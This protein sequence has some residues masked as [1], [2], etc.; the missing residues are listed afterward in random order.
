VFSHAARYSIGGRGTLREVFLGQTNLDIIK[1]ASRSE[2]SVVHDR[3]FLF[4]DIT[5]PDFGEKDRFGQRFSGFF[6]PPKS[7]LYTF[8]VRSDDWSR[9]Y[10]SPNSS[11]DHAKL[12]IS[13]DSH[14]SHRY[15]HFAFE[16][17]SVT[18]LATFLLQVGSLSTSVL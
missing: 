8:N 2:K 7:S 14:T 5:E 4:D 17:A 13:V 10:L 18:D 1:Q 16:L 9:L 15:T 12:I 6:V 3:L 11:A